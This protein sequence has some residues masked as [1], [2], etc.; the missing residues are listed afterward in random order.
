MTG[1]IVTTHQ[2]GLEITTKNGIFR[3][4]EYVY[5]DVVERNPN[6]NILFIERYEEEKRKDIGIQNIHSKHL[7]YIEIQTKKKIESDCLKRKI[8]FFN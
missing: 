4:I 1:T 6:T 3:C 7:L 8:N 5:I 2:R